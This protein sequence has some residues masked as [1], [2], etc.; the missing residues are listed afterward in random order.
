MKLKRVLIVVLLVVSTVLTFKIII[1]KYNNANINVNKERNIETI[2]KEFDNKINHIKVVE[3]EDKKV[4]ANVVGKIV[5]NKIILNYPILEGATQKN[6]NVS[7][8]RFCGSKVNSIGN[9]VLAGHNM[10]NGSLFGKLSTMEKGDN[11]ILYDNLGKKKE[12]KIFNIKVVAPTNISVLSQDT[13]NCRW[14]TLIT[15]SNHGKNRLIIQ[16]KEV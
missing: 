3:S 2:N 4:M 16:A 5:I 10:K 13:N 9:C 15:C 11:I 6:L 1:N 8:T 12:Y 7:I 14:V